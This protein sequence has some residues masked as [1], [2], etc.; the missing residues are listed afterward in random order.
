M[1]SRLSL[2]LLA[3]AAVLL[4]QEPEKKFGWPLTIH[5]GVSSSFQE[6]RSSHFHAGIDMR[7]MQRTGFPVLAVADGVIE[8]LTMTQRNY[9][10]CLLLRHAGGYSS[11]YGHL[12]KFRADLEAIVSAE[13]AGRGE[14]YFGDLLLPAPIAVRR[15][16]VIAFSGESGAGFA[17]LH[18][19]IRDGSDRAV[20]PLTLIG[21]QSFDGN[22]PRIRGVLLRSR[23]G[24]LVNG[25]C[26]EFYF[27][28]RKQ[29]DAYTLAEPLRINGPCDISLDAFDLSDVRHIIAPIG[30]EASLDGR[31]VFRAYFDRLSRDDNNQLGMLYDMA[32][33]TPGTYFFNICSRDGFA[34]EGTGARLADELQRLAPGLHEIRIRVA[35]QQRNQALAILPIFKV[36]AGEPRSFGR[37]A[38]ASAAGNGLMQESEFTTFINQGDLVVMA[39]DFPVAASRLKLKVSQGNSEQVIQA[40]EYA[41]GVFFC[42]QPLNHEPR[43]L[44]R[45]ELSDNGL[46]VEAR[47]KMLQVVWLKNN[48]AQTARLGDFRAEFGPT[49]VREPTVLLLE[50]VALQPEFPLLG[51]AVRSEPVHFAF[52]DTVHYKFRVPAGTERPAQLG[53]FKYHPALKRWFYVPT[54]PDREAGYVSCRVLT[55]GTFALLRDIFPPAV[56]LRR[57]GSRSL[58][59]LQS[60]VVRLSD[61]GKGIDDTS[62]EVFLNGRPVEAEYDPDWRRALLE[63]LPFL[64]K[65]RN[66]LLVRVADLAGNRS[67]KRFNFSLR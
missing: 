19:E 13:Q 4:P 21:D 52:L 43:L 8:K 62:L 22:P 46:T 12:E 61:K 20:N 10:R 58:G 42:F 55:A 25:D 35:D 24:S 40:R 37:K 23:G 29:G 45:F 65:G 38:A 41:H 39:R 27:K 66:E 1:K 9:G 5:D 59:R 57:P 7:T 18:L 15:G 49:T 28:L 47:Q 30:L 48:L 54:Q 63:K 17:H 51:V 44:L 11:L 33:S 3:A 67:E 50:P 34:L 16:E 32:Y 26:G 36:P 53:I 60:L 2:L 64:R 31:P 56:S 6:F 14:K